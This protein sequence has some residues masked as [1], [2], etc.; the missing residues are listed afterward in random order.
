[1]DVLRSPKKISYDSRPWREGRCARSN[2]RRLGLGETDLAYRTDQV[3][4]PGIVSLANLTN[5]LPK[6]VKSGNVQTEQMFSG[7]HLKADARRLQEPE[8]PAME[9]VKPHSRERTQRF[10]SPCAV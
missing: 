1:L 5:L 9:R 3:D 7:L 6:Q 10:C 2:Q 4:A 8:A